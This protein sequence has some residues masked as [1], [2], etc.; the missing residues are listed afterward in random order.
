MSGPE[1]NGEI[2]AQPAGRLGG[3]F[4][5]ILTAIACFLSLLAGSTA[6]AADPAVIDQ[7]TS[8]ATMIGRA[9]ACGCDTDRATSRVGGWLD[10]SFSGQE[11]GFYMR[12]LTT[13]MYNAAKAQADGRSPDSCATVCREMG[14]VNWP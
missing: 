10:R 3:N 6:F 8:Y 4:M 7:V 12:I 13:G 2:D 1:N 11:K 5:R 9:S 14:K